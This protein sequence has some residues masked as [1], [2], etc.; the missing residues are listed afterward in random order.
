[1]LGCFRFPAQ[2]W[3]GRSPDAALV[4]GSVNSLNRDTVLI[5]PSL[6]EFVNIPQS[7]GIRGWKYFRYVNDKSVE[8]LYSRR[9]SRDK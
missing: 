1:M 6:V 9:S 5:E 7:E 3:H 4:S 2:N 8:E